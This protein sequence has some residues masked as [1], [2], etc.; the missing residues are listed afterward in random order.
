MRDPNPSVMEEPAPAGGGGGGSSSQEY[1]NT[2][3]GSQQSGGGGGGYQPEYGGSGGVGP[4][5]SAYRDNNGPRGAGFPP[6]QVARRQVDPY[7]NRPDASMA[8]SSGASSSR[9][10]HDI[11]AP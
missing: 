3:P 10:C 11:L 1:Y 6:N 5:S 2:P 8:S 7:N 9:R 4:S